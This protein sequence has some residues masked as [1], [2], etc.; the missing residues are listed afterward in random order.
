M[1]AKTFRKPNN[2]S[3]VKMVRTL[4][5]KMKDEIVLDSIRR[6]DIIEK[7]LSILLER[8]DE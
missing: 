8:F 4:A 6:L 1:R 7:Y 3:E 5:D 2:V